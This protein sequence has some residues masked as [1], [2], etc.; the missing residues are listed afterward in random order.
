MVVL[1][2]NMPIL[3]GYDACT[4][5]LDQFR[6][7]MSVMKPYMVALT[8]SVTQNVQNQCIVAGFDLVLQ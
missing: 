3:D 6:E 8:A 1:D 4:K 2:L 5:I 7:N